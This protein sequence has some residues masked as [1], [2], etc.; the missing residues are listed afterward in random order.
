[1]W[2]TR[3][4]MQVDTTV[5]EAVSN[6]IFNAVRAMVWVGAVQDEAD[7]IHNAIN[8]EVGDGQN[9]RSVA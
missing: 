5:R 1:M 4:A 3:F 6:V 9:Q 8:V 2:L 7:F